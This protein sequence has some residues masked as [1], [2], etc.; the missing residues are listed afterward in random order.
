MT[1]DRPAMCLDYRGTVDGSD[2]LKAEIEA[3][4]AKWPEGAQVRH[5]R[6]GTKG[7][8]RLDSPASVPGTFPGQPSAWCIGHDGAPWV[9]VVW[10][11][12]SAV[13]LRVWQPARTLRL[14]GLTA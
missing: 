14:T 6:F 7:V 8:I 12:K 11:T 10:G 5:R 2:A 1:V 3:L 4:A 13:P 9:C